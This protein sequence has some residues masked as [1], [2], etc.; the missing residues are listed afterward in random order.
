[1]EQER[2]SCR[3]CLFRFY[4]AV[5]TPRPCPPRFRPMQQQPRLSAVSGLFIKVRLPQPGKDGKLFVVAVLFCH[6]MPRS[7]PVHALLFSLPLAN[8][9]VAVTGAAGRWLAGGGTPD[10]R[11][12]LRFGCG[13]GKVNTV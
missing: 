9:A 7:R 6:E 12:L 3:F 5:L 8:T 2:V 10:A 11:P 4:A 13:L 1:M